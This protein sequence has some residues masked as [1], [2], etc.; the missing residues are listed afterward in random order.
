MGKGEALKVIGCTDKEELVMLPNGEAWI[1]VTSPN[2]PAQD[3]SEDS[4]IDGFTRE[5]DKKDAPRL[6]GHLKIRVQVGRLERGAAA[7]N[8]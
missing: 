8:P 7:N 2:E 5:L 4:P 3:P 1:L 6:G